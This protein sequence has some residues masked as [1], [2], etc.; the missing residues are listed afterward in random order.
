MRSLRVAT[1]LGIVLLAQ[2]AAATP[3]L[4]RNRRA[5][6]GARAGSWTL[7]PSRAG[8]RSCSSSS[9]CAAAEVY[10]AQK[11]SGASNAA[12]GQDAARRAGPERA[13]QAAVL[14][15][16]A[17]RNVDV[18][19][20]V[21]TA[22]NGIA[23]QASPALADELG[24]LPGVEAVHQIS[25]ELR[26]N[27][28][29]VP[30]IGAAGGMAEHGPCGRGESASG[31]I[32]TGIDYVTRTSAAPAARR[33]SRSREVLATNSRATRLR[34][35][36][37]SASSTPRGRS[38]I[39][40]RRS[41]GAST[42]R[43]MRTPAQAA[44]RRR[45]PTRIR[46]TAR[47]RSAAATGRAP[48]ARLP[49][50]ES[51]A[52]GT[53]YAGPYDSATPFSTLRIG[54]GVAPKRSS[55]CCASS[56]APARRGL[57]T[58]A[59][60]WAVDPNGDGNPSDHLDVINMS[61]GSPTGSDD[62]P[63]AASSN[64]ASA[65]GRDRRD[66]GSATAATS[67]Y[68]SG[69]PGSATRAIAT[70]ATTDDQD[71]TDGF[72]VVAPRVS[73]RCPTGFAQREASRPG[74]PRPGSRSPRTCT[75]RPRTSTAAVWTD[76][77]DKA[78]IAGKI[79]L[80]DW[81]KRPTRRSPL[82]LRQFARTMR[83]LAGAVG[84]IMVDTTRGS[85]TRSLGNAAIP[86]MYSTVD[87]GTPVEEPARLRDRDARLTNAFNNSA[88]LHVEG[89]N[90]TVSSFSSRGLQGRVNGLKP[91]LA[92]PGQGVFSI[93]RQ[94]AQ[95]GQEPER[96]VDGLAPRRG[97]HGA[98]EAGA[99][100]LDG[101][102]TER[103]WRSTRRRRTPS[104][105]SAT[106]VTSTAPDA[107]APGRVNVPDAL[108]TDAVAF[109]D[110]GSGAVSVSFGALQ[111]AGLADVR[112]DGQ[113]RESRLL[114]CDVQRRLRSARR[115]R[116]CSAVSF[117][118]AAAS[119]QFAGQSATFRVALSVDSSQL[120]A[121]H[122]STVTETQA[123][124]LGVQPR[125]WLTEFNGLVT[126]TLRQARRCGSGLC[127]RPSRVEHEHDREH[128]GRSH[129]AGLDGAPLTGTGIDTGGADEQGLPPRLV[130][131]FE[132]QGRS[133][134]ATLP[135]ELARIRT[136]RGHQAGRRH[137]GREVERDADDLLLCQ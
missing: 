34:T 7:R 55:T 20:Q 76:A 82:R 121:V 18:L 63:S 15:L 35:R 23:V 48:P 104:P 5:R 127:G 96:H 67:F 59:I 133:G 107:S 16:L 57:T 75:T 88:K 9:S 47:R 10:A 4:S 51:N 81:K 123:T 31:V 77:A 40:P 19:Y 113:G 22:Y 86:G 12:A 26:S 30:L 122:E 124:Q 65:G 117:P 92:A 94:H 60:D 73:C 137:V 53:T 17:A 85:D 27:A 2:A 29:T 38:C 100:G 70:A 91:D 99:P 120:R 43:E 136:R 44:A 109:V 11:D 112:A 25:L 46:R 115:S 114:G 37:G 72:E 50:T 128:G 32:D 134:E 68:V 126:L 106:R 28:N 102:G 108:S 39:R 41:P 66:P 24:N 129:L 21:Q 33:I 119:R 49:G 14:A 101:R 62:D 105:A 118:T 42:S 83:R 93:R 132:H 61:L 64:N 74:R 135:A 71:I 8:S 116:R 36:P 69:S 45:I 125:H 97:R 58:Q 90:D 87:V 110:G 78:A 95:P 80:V 131:A 6:A 54:P 52:D 56:A 111:V 13:A 79:V 103:R 3:N 1:V 84:I 89:W 98:P 130:S